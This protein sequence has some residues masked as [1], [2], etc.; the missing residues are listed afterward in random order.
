MWVSLPCM[1]L[2]A[3]LPEYIVSVLF[4]SSSK[5]NGARRNMMISTWSD[6][7]DPSIHCELDCDA[8]KIPAFLE[9]LSKETGEKLT[10]T[11]LVVKALGLTLREAPG[12]RGRLLFS[13]YVPFDTVDVSCLVVMEK[14]EN[15]SVTTVRNVDHLPMKDIA[16]KVRGAARTLRAEK[17]KDFEKSVKAQ[18]R[19]PTCLLRTVA[20]FAG[21]VS[22][23]LGI[24]V[25]ALGSKRFHFGSCMV[26]SLGSIGL[27]KA[28]V[29]LTPFARTPMLVSVG[30]M[31][32]APVVEGEGDDCK[33]VPRLTLPLGITIDHRFVDGAHT[34]NMARNLRRIIENPEL[35]RADGTYDI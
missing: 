31:K 14:S 2:V 26:T 22:N 11:H 19:L 10:V 28:C 23:S 32:M 1:V 18:A 15:L 4:P 29:P 9:K 20:W 34:L 30:L 7:S 13:R 6:P 21:Y 17:D 3:V 5:F 12:L 35:I 16:V 33:V 8:R 27:D 24:D 25:S